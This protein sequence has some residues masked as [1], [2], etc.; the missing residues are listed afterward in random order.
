MMDKITTVKLRE[1]KRAGEKIAMLTAYDYTTAKLLNDAGIDVLLVGDSLGMVKRGYRDTLQVTV[2][3]VVFYCKAVKNGNSRALLIADMP[4]MSYETSREDAVRNAGRIIKLGGAEAV[5]IE[6]GVEVVDKIKAIIAAKIPVMGHIG[7]TPQAVHQMGGY[8]VQGR[9]SPAARKLVNAAKQLEKA[10]V[11]SIVLECI[12][13]ILAKRITASV[14]VPTIGIGAGIH[15]DGQ[16]LVIDDVLG[17][18]SE[19]RPKFVKQYA[20]LRRHVLKAASEY[21]REVKQGKFPA[22]ENTYK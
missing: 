20:N 3:E 13:G 11:F 22:E 14:S 1:M 16:V 18:Y 21:K 10:G 5:K 7:L 6:G 9:S 12:P 8:K 4:F 17:L 19:M 15:C 2:D